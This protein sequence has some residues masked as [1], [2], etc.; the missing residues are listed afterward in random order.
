MSGF[1]LLEDGTG[2]IELE[3]GT[4]NLMLEADEFGRH[5]L[6]AKGEDLTI[7]AKHENNVLIVKAED[8]TSRSR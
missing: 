6:H 1:F 8:T 2:F 5:M 3:N 7:R 4:G